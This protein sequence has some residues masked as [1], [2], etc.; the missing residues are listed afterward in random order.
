MSINFSL[1]GIFWFNDGSFFIIHNL[2]LAL[3]A[4]ELP[5]NFSS[6]NSVV[7]QKQKPS[8]NQA[9]GAWSSP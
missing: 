3:Q 9:A 5:N 1:Q 2:D 7:A 6:R 8:G 4:L